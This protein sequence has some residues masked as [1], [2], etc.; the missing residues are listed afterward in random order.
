MMLPAR[1]YVSDHT[2]FMRELLEEK[3]QLV[4]EQ[5]KARARWWDKR[6]VEL[7]AEQKMEEG[8]VPLPGYVYQPE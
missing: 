4:E 1:H 2:R 8:R 7:A 6:P 5:K 3:P